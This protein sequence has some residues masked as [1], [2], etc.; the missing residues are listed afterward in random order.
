M[1]LYSLSSLFCKLGMMFLNPSGLLA[2]P[3]AWG[4]HSP[5]H[6]RS[7]A[8]VTRPST[9]PSLSP[10]GPPEVP[11]GRN[12]LGHTSTLQPQKQLLD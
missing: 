10:E 4:P 2:G 12:F 1:V 11:P 6:P 9:S 8:R 5:A 7:L 3:A